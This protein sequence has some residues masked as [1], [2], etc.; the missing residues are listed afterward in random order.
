MKKLVSALVAAAVSAISVPTLGA[1]WLYQLEQTKRF[2][3]KA[4]EKRTA[5]ER[6]AK[7]R[8]PAIRDSAESSRPGTSSAPSKR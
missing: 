7:D 8:R 5:K 1:D 2:Q 4:A 3:E 6:E